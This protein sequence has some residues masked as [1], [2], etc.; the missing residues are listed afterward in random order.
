MPENGP[1]IHNA[2]LAWSGKGALSLRTLAPSQ[3]QSR[4]DM[5]RHGMIAE[6]I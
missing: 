6:T 1:D 4:G 2:Y 3:K 5:M